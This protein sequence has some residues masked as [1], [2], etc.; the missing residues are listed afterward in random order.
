[1]NATFLRP[2]YVLG[3]HHRWPYVLLPAYWLLERIPPVSET[4]K[5]LGLVT[6]DQ[7]LTALVSAVESEPAGVRIVDVEMIRNARL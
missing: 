7:M 4:A 3:P 6:L 2:W 1:M 5:R